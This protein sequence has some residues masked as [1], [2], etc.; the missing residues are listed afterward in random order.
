MSNAKLYFSYTKANKFIKTFEIIINNANFVLKIYNMSGQGYE[1]LKLLN[2]KI[3]DLVNRFNNLKAEC[4]NLRTGKEALTTAL[5]YRETE[6][7]ELEKKYE[8]VKLS[9]ALL[10]DSEN[11]SEGKKKI[12]ELVREIDNC[13]ALLDR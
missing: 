12:T 8:R 5:L 9:G 11:A 4:E 3:D 6:M 1:E 13:I 10:G 7:K 2:R